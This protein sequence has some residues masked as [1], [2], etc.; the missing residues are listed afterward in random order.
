MMLNLVLDIPVAKKYS[1]SDKERTNLL[2]DLKKNHH[3]GLVELIPLYKPYTINLKY[4]TLKKKQPLLYYI[5]EIESDTAA[6]QNM[7]IENY[8][9]LDFPIYIK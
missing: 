7:C 5:N 4:L 3:K 9:E 8:Y 2:L 6:Y 1:L